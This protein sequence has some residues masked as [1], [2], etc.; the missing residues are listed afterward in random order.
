MREQNVTVSDNGRIVLPVM[1]RKQLNINPGDELILS[2]SP[3]NDII[4]HSPK[5]SLQKL[6]DLVAKK[7][8]TNLVETLIEMRRKEEI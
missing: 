7:H 1:F 5:Q 8:K 3:D 2:V 6:Q 4:V